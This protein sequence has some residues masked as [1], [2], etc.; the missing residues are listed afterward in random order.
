MLTREKP[1]TFRIG[2]ALN[3]GKSLLSQICIGENRSCEKRAAPNAATRKSHFRQRQRINDTGMTANCATKDQ[4]RLALYE[5]REFE[6]PRT[7]CVDAMTFEI[8]RFTP[9]FRCGFLRKTP[10]ERNPTIGDREAGLLHRQ[11]QGG[12]LMSVQFRHMGRSQ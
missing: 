10:H 2:Y 4:L 9:K 11:G 5:K 1:Q 8:L 7:A 6:N 12:Q 3:S